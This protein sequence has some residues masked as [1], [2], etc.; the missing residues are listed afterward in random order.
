ME[1]GVIAPSVDD[2]VELRTKLKTPPPPP[3]P[4]PSEGNDIAGDGTGEKRSACQ[5]FALTKAKIGGKERIFAPI[6]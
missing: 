2:R 4:P 6:E 5:N 3:P 1:F